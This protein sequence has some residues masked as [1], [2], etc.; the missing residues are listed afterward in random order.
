MGSDIFSVITNSD[1]IKNKRLYFYQISNEALYK[2]R[3]LSKEIIRDKQI[4]INDEKE[5]N[6][7]RKNNLKI[8][9]LSSDQLKFNKEM[10]KHNTIFIFDWDDTLFFTSH[11]DP[12]NTNL[13][14]NETPKEKRMMKSIEYYVQEILIKA[15]SK[16]TV[17]II[18]NS[19]EGWVQKC[20]Y[21]YYPDLVPL[22][23]KINII[24]ARYL[25]EKEYP[26]MPL[27]WKI[28]AFNDLKENFDFN[29]CPLTNIISIGDDNSEIIAAKNLSKNFENCLIKTIKLRENP[30]LKELIKQLILVNEQILR[31]YSYPKSLTIQVGKTKNPKK[32]Q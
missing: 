23:K 20:T 16:G 32:N 22:L 4:N 19:S 18:T 1:S 17:V 9:K 30:N 2:K 6:K 26:F 27:M 14:S 25:Y 29:N 10:L 28:K 8:K 31:I 13:L 3:S 5:E 21:Y 24:S 7:K 11:L 12:L 15:L